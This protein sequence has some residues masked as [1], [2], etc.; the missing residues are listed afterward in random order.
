MSKTL[1]VRIANKWYNVEID[2]IKARPIKALVD[3]EVVEVEIET[4]PSPLQK[5]N[6][7]SV[8]S[9]P[10]STATKATKIFHTPMP[11]IIV[12]VAVKEGDQIVTG[13]EICVLEAMKM[14]QTLR[15]EW[16]GVVKVVHVS[17]SQQVNTGDPIVELQ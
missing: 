10:D 12:S 6:T 13:D 2:D 7:P 11:G 3:G 4:S 16:S 17:S 14:Q 9:T 8:V 5:S 1:R 15:A